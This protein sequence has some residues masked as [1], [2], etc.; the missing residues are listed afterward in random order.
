MYIR[1]TTTQHKSD[2]VIYQIY[3]LVESTRI[4]NTVRQ[5]ALLNLGSHYP[6][7][8]EQW[9]ALTDE[10][11]LYCRSSLRAAKEEAMDSQ[12]EQRF[13][14]KM[15]ALAEGLPKKGRTKNH[16]QARHIFLSLPVGF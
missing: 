15:K 1:Q 10:P 12:C 9:G 5:H 7:L 2:G 14:E 4:G 8:R 11:E 6:I 13:V 3:R 16:D